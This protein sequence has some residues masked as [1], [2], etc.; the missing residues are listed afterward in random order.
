VELG[1]VGS[2]NTEKPR[3]QRGS[4]AVMPL[5]A[6]LLPQPYPY[7]CSFTICSD[8]DYV[9][10]KAFDA[11]H[12]FINTTGSTHLGEGL[13]L[14][15]ADS[16]FMY[17]E[18]PGVLSYF[19]GT[20]GNLSRESGLLRE[21]IQEGWI[22]SL[23]G[24]GD[25]LS[26]HAFS[27]ELAERALDELAKNNIKL[28]IWIDH[29]SADNSQ[30]IALPNFLSRGA[31]PKHKAYHTDL[32]KQYGIGFVAGYNSD[33]IGQDG[34]RVK[35]ADSLPQPEVPF[36]LAKKLHGRLYGRKLLRRKKYRDGTVFYSFCRA[37]NGVLRPDAST[38]S[39]QL[40]RR[41]IQRLIQSGGTM[42]LYQHLGSAKQKV[43]E[44][45]YLDREARRALSSIAEK[46]HDKTIWVA[47]T[48]R[49][50]THCF[51][52]ETMKLHAS[53][54]KGEVLVNITHTG[55]PASRPDPTAFH[56]ISFR[57]Q[58]HHGNNIRI[59]W[60]GYTFKRAEYE[61]FRDHGTVIKMKPSTK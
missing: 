38:L 48:S 1:F 5:K 6:D 16:V 21:A 30:N 9:T 60:G 19:Q 34:S 13:G 28:K 22:D 42:I 52:R 47:P 2:L 35:R 10:P 46:Y 32:L 51:M 11:I 58:N 36:S 45:P 3:K 12:R 56:D 15:I 24:Y 8:C 27:R 57:V 31:N 33:L 61:L 37:R 44:F 54:D 7:K 4:S 40:G 23:H 18:R 43:N 17:G 41:T 49:I 29:G 20:S 53:Q 39:H 50:L 14:P 59:T 25:F 55:D 26:R